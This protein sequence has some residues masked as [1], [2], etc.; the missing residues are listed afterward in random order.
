M[1]QDRPCCCRK[2]GR[3]LCLR[4]LPSGQSRVQLLEG[5]P[6]SL[7]AAQRQVGVSEEQAGGKPGPDVLTDQIGL[8]LFGCY[9]RLSR[10]I[11]VFCHGNIPLRPLFHGLCRC[12]A[13]SR[14]KSSIHQGH[15]ISTVHERY[16]R[17]R[18]GK[19]GILGFFRIRRDRPGSGKFSG[20]GNTS[21]DAQLLHHT[22][23]D[24]PFFGGLLYREIFH[25]CTSRD[26]FLFSII[27]AHTH[28]HKSCCQDLTE[29]Q[30]SSCKSGFCAWA[31]GS[32]LRY[33]NSLD[34][35]NAAKYL[36]SIKK[37]RQY[38]RLFYITKY[39]SLQFRVLQSPR[40]PDL[41]HQFHHRN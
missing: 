11:V 25:C 37:S 31:E 29:R 15:E 36:L 6:G 21:I 24:S 16:R 2:G 13:L 14:R 40:A 19:P 39:G 12:Q 35:K 10:K 22:P 41:V 20:P 8:R 28:R 23:G 3:G 32:I 1:K 26:K 7:N 34:C 30:L 27:C 4:G 38:W 9:L 5:M 33:Y 18:L 17:F